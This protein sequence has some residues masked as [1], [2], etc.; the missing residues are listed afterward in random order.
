M[1]DLSEAHTPTLIR[2]AQQHGVS[3]ADI[4]DLLEQHEL[5]PTVAEALLQLGTVE[6]RSLSR[7]GQAAEYSREVAGV[8]SANSNGSGLR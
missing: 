8:I 4:E 5:S 1:V 2:L 6:F 3:V 7:W